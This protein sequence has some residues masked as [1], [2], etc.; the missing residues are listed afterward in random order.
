MESLRVTV[1][2]LWDG[3]D[4]IDIDLISRDDCNPNP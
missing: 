3:T 2:W 4:C 1:G